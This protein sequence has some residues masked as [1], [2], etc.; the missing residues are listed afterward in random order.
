MLNA[1]EAFEVFL[2]FETTFGGLAAL[3]PTP[4]VI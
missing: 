1:D 2:E 3:K 4:A